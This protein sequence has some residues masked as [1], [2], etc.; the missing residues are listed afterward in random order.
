MRNPPLS[1]QDV[2]AWQKAQQLFTG[3][4]RLL[5]D[6]PRADRYWLAPQLGRAALSV[7]SNIAEGKGREHLGDYLHH[8][9]YARGST[10]ELHSDLIC[11]RTTEI[12][13]AARV[14]PLEGL[15]DEVSR[16]IATMAS[17]L[18]A[19]DQRHRRR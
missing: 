4:Y 18:R 2:V 17:R 15:C 13:R 12:V 11:L 5:D 9:S 16:M 10:H 19:H 14:E 8:L 1:F 3:V 7:P 6:L